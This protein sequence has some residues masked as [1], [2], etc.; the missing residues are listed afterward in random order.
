MT[1]EIKSKLVLTVIQYNNNSFIGIIVSLCL[2]SWVHLI[3]HSIKDV[4]KVNDSERMRESKIID[5]DRNV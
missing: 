1:K 3:V 4:G 2:G 5:V